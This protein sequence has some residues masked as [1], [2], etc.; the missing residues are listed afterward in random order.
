[1][2]HCAHSDPDGA[3]LVPG[4]DAKVRLHIVKNSLARKATENSKLKGFDKLLDGPSAVVYGPKASI[5]QIARILLDEKN[6][7]PTPTSTCIRCSF[8]DGFPCL[9]NGK[10][11]AQVV[12]VEPSPAICGFL[13]RN[14]ER[15]GFGNVIEVLEA[16]VR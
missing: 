8:Y 7:Q 12:C 14:V 6:G 5:S 3:D 16:A 11:D 10:A 1:M 15:N 9:L 13:R 2:S 4:I